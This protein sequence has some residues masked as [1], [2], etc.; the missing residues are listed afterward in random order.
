MRH[1]SS[2]SANWSSERQQNLFRRLLNT[3]WRERA[4]AAGHPEENIEEAVVNDVSAG[5]TSAPPS[6]EMRQSM[7]VLDLYILDN[8]PRSE[9]AI[10]QSYYDKAFKARKSGKIEEAI[11]LYTAAFEA[12]P[13]FLAAHNEVGV[14]L[15]QTGNLRDA[16]KIYLDVYERPNAGEQRYI[17][18]TN[19]ADV[20]LTWFDAGRNR[21]RNIERATHFARL[22]MEHPTPMR[23]CNLVLA[24]VK[25]RYYVEAQ[26][27]MNSVL[28]ADLRE[29]PGEK[30]LQTLFQI[31]DA[32]LVTWWTWLDC[33]LDKASTKE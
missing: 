27:V 2:P 9:D 3:P 25:D 16:L 11:R 10:A 26:Q 22:A 31:R 24:F 6:P 5:G 19:A 17:A 4:E 8:D 30:F 18:A 15:M 29:C 1:K 20:Y 21:E 23:A 14:L 12:D 33:E 13:S 7:R 32:D 28:Q